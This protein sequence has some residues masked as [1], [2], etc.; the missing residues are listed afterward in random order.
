[1]AIYLKDFKVASMEQ[2]AD[3]YRNPKMKM[4]TSGGWYPFNIFPEKKI[5]RFSFDAPITI[6]YGSNEFRTISVNSAKGCG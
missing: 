5:Y 4:S 6:L 3:M 1:M 2:E